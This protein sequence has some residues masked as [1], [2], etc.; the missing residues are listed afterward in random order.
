MLRGNLS[1]EEGSRTKKDFLLNFTSRDEAVETSYVTSHKIV[2][3]QR[4]VRRV[5]P[6]KMNET[7]VEVDHLET[8]G[9][10]PRRKVKYSVCL[11]D[12]Y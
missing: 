1:D 8:S 4:E 11:S 6:E 10:F 12:V 3:L 5:R 7:L 2:A 9:T